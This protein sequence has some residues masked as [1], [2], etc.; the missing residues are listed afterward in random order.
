MVD[1]SPP[2]N[3]LLG[4]PRGR[5]GARRLGV[6]EATRSIPTIVERVVAESSRPAAEFGEPLPVEYRAFHRDGRIAVDPRGLRS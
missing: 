2:S 1:V 4:I 6:W 3:Q 5:N